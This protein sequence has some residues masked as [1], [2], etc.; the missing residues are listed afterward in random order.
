MFSRIYCK[1]QNVDRRTRCF[2]HNDIYHAGNSTVPSSPFGWHSSM[3]L[4]KSIRSLALIFSWQYIN[5]AVLPW[6]KF[7]LPHHCFLGIVL[8]S[9]SAMF[10]AGNVRLRTAFMRQLSCRGDN[11]QSFPLSLLEFVTTMKAI[12]ATVIA[13]AHEHWTN[14]QAVYTQAFRNQ[15]VPRFRRHSILRRIKKYFTSTCCCFVK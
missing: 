13:P 6:L 10:A 15:L 5:E 4:E 9:P 3:F 14:I 11:T 8:K 12:K 7:L 2:E 1:A